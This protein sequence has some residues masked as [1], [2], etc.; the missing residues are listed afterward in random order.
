M[1]REQLLA[2]LVADAA[3]RYRRAGLFAFLFARGKLRGDP[4]YAALLARGLIEDRSAVLDLGCGQGLLAAWLEA[5]TEC[6][7]R[8]TWHEQWKSPPEL[9]S[10]HGIELS[11]REV[12]RARAALGAGA[13]VER[14]DIRTADYRAADVV[15]LLDVLHYIDPPG[16]ER[17]LQRVRGA[18]KPAGTLLMRVGDAG[19]GL[20][21]S[22]SRLLDRLVRICRGHGT[23]RLYT[24]T[25]GEWASLLERAG[26]ASFPTPMSEGTPFANVLIVAIPR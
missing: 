15:V 10:Y 25:L 17:I 9:R 11:A 13:T 16:Q 18:L 23:G 14:A 21:F 8:G 7:G 4:I 26:F 19:A 22:V 1:T 6:H 12:T 5:A 2:R 24:R 20:G 3:A